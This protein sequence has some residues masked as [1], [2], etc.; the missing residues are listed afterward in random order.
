MRRGNGPGSKNAGRIVAATPGCVKATYLRIDVSIARLQK[1]A[2][3]YQLAGS[4]LAP[5]ELARANLR[6]KS[7]PRI[8]LL[9]GLDR[10]GGIAH[11]LRWLVRRNV[12]R[13]RLF[14]AA[15]RMPIS[16]VPPD[17]LPF[18]P[19]LSSPE[20]QTA[21][22]VHFPTTGDVYGGKETVLR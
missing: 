6:L 16:A 17:G 19:L 14:W 9:S 7:C 13:G 4:L 5:R 15:A 8:Q 21:G 12:L 22:S 11:N 10:R 2:S 20:S 3:A 1:C 18:W